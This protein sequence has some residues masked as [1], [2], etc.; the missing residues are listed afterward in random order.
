[1]HENATVSSATSGFCFHL[2]TCTL[3][4]KELRIAVLIIGKVLAYNQI[5]TQLK[6]LR[7]LY[8]S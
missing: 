6:R 4:E 5:L 8:W 2:R 3:E 1:M 7:G